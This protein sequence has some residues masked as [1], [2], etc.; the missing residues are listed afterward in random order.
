MDLQKIVTKALLGGIITV[1]SIA[2]VWAVDASKDG[3]SVPVMTRGRAVLKVDDL[4]TLIG[5]E[6]RDPSSNHKREA[7]EA[8]H[9]IVLKLNESEKKSLR[10]K[11]QAIEMQRLKLEQKLEKMALVEKTKIREKRKQI[12]LSRIS[13][14]SDVDSS[15]AKGLYKNILEESNLT[16]RH[17]Q[18]LETFDATHVASVDY[19]EVSGKRHV[20]G[21]AIGSKQVWAAARA[22]MPL[23][24]AQK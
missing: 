15:L 12:Q 5:F 21:I 10:G 2:Q 4:K 24:I 22:Q 20:N 19:T 3:A 16:A 23:E 9:S 7:I 13:A 6:G 11:I 18:V 1:T 17:A 14:K 8:N